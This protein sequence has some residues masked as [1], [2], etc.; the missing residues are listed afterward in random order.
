MTEQGEPR[1]K[2]PNPQGKGLVPVLQDIDALPAQYRPTKS[3]LDFFRDYCLSSLV[4]AA[5][6]RFRP[7]PDKEYFLYSTE[8]G[9][10]LSLV[11]PA[12]WHGNMP[13]VYVAVCLLRKDMTWRV[14][15]TLLDDHE[16]VRQKIENFAASFGESVSN[17]EN[18]DGTLPFFAANLPYFH[19]VMATGLAVSLKHSMPQNDS[20]QL[21]LEYMENPTSLLGS[22]DSI[23][24]D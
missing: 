2:N 11:A 3:P 18:L 7:V 23:K 10:T 24:P 8:V 4:L 19:R 12:E 17:V 9:W 20:L 6:F 5:H 22:S 13:G 1:R 14:D 21:I 15:F 16:D